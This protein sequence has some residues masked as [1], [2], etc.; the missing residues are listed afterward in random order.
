[1]S[2]PSKQPNSGILLPTFETLLLTIA[3]GIATVTLNRPSVL[4]ALN[5]SLFDD[6]ERVFQFLAQDPETRAVV[7]TGAGGKA[8]A[9]GA[10]LQEVAQIPDAAGGEKLALR[11]QA[12]F[13]LIETLPKP[14]IAAVEGFALGGGLELALS[15]TFRLASDA[16]K[17]GLPEIK[18]GLLPGYG[19]SQ[20]LPRLVGRSAALKL[21]LTGDMIS[22]AEALRL[23]LV[24][25]VVSP[26]DLLPRANDLATRIA[27]GP[28]LAISA[29]LEA[30]REGSPLPLAEALALEARLFGQ[31]F[32]TADK[33][34]GVAA[35]LQKRV[36]HWTGQ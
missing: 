9:A 29:I 5:A 17:L 24:D 28:Q 18:L 19:G 4:N 14:V 8:F 23:G 32:E 33:R 35:F 13:R 20:R 34:E 36:P 15:C 27:G 6:L 21:L 31:L 10:D 12:V 1:M 2:E 11:G 22:A 30:V 3:G 26:A 7:L 25:G 16:A